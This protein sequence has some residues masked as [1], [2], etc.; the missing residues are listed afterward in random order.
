M[1]KIT[2]ISIL[3]NC[4]FVGCSQ[5]F[6]PG[7]SFELFKNTSNWDLAKAVENENEKEI[8]RLIKDGNANINLQESKFGRTLLHL[9]VGNDKLIS[10]EI[11]LQEGADLNLKDSEG[12]TAIQEATRSINFKKNSFQILE[13]LLNF[14]AN[15]NDSLVTENNG[16]IDFFYVPL[17]GAS[18]NLKCTKLLLEKG[19]NPYIKNDRAFLFWSVT[20]GDPRD[21]SIDVLKY[22]II[23]KK[24]PVPDP[25]AYSIPDN[26]PLNIYILLNR[27]DFATD[28]KKENARQEILNYL[29]KNNFPKYDV[30]KEN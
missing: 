30:Y 22:L 18:K 20:L 28:P 13:L 25:I 4:F 11:L 7:Y 15:P 21:E 19:A 17:M 5:N 6:G 9:A 27:I 3:I 10:T 23:D 12:Y 29:H 24:M 26:K 1:V 14:G 16:T 8:K 2:M